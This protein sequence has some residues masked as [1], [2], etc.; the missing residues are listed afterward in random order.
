MKQIKMMTLLLLICSGAIAQK[1]PVIHLKT[2]ETYILTSSMENKT[3][4][5]AMGQEIEAL[6]NSTS[7]YQ[8]EV[9]E[10]TD[11]VY[12]LT[13][14]LTHVKMSA[15]N[16]GQEMTYDSD[17]TDDSSNPLGAAFGPYLNK[18]KDVRITTS[19]KIL[20]DSNAVEERDIS[21]T[22]LQQLEN[23]GYG[24]RIAFEPL[25]SNPDVGDTWTI[26]TEQDGIVR[27]TVYSVISIDENTATIA[28]TGTMKSD[29]TIESQGMEI[30]TNTAGKF[31][32]EEKVNIETGMVISSVSNITTTGTVNAM[33]N[34][35]PVNA[36]I[37]I[38]THTKE[39]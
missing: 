12:H 15:S 32:G 1:N 21:S 24:A 19:G 25:P 29:I 22:A 10:K 30:T 17:S 31:T 33:G 4:T 20:E 8:L 37:T 16:M 7:T 18:P 14:T 26:N 3:V 34:E 39:K 23:S 11:S 13:S 6:I 5:N 28:Y 35:F 27:N 9:K 2:G 36:D 38:T